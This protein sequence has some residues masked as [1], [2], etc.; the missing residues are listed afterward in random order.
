MKLTTRSRFAVT[1]MIDL[2]LYGEKEPVRLTD[3]ARREQISAAYL[4]QI[5]NKLRRAN[6]VTSVRGPGGGYRL[7]RPPEEINAG[8]IVDA[9][10]DSVDQLLC[11]GVVKCH[12]GA[13]C[14]THCLWADLDKQ[15]SLFLH[16]QTL[17]SI[18][19]NY[20]MSCR[21]DGTTE[22]V[23]VFKHKL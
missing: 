15:I 12:R 22:S 14:L 6:L 1:S 23:I 5:F 17:A 18:K 13:E 8:E 11:N 10:E 2:V 16:Q 3:I 7:A 4:E 21:T 20:P 19:A 9:V